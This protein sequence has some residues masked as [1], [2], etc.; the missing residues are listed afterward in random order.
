[1]PADGH[2]VRLEFNQQTDLLPHPAQKPNPRCQPAADV[3]SEDKPMVAVLE[4]R[5][6]VSDKSLEILGREGRRSSLSDVDRAP[7]PRA[8]PSRR[9]GSGTKTSGVP[10]QAG[11]V[12]LRDLG[13]RRNLRRPRATFAYSNNT[14]PATTA[15]RTTATNAVPFQ[16]ATT[17]PSAY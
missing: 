6:L 8:A 3:G 15:T 5:G 14:S 9:R 13:D 4:V 12:I 11:W 7:S 16:A 10:G 2:V 1:M 17:A